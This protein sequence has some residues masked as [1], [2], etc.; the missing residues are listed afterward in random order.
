M[1]VIDDI[2]FLTVLIFCLTLGLAPFAPPHVWEKLV[3]LFNGTLVRPIDMFDW[4]M[5]GTPWL[6]L[7][8]KVV[9]MRRGDQP[10]D[11]G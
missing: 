5:H 6:I 10:S 1:S 7:G 11:E 4:L 3:M 2:P 8:V 9:R